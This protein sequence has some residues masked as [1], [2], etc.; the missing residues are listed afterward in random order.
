MMMLKRWLPPQEDFFQCFQTAVRHLVSAATCFE[1]LLSD[2]SRADD[3][4]QQIAQFE[5]Q[6][7]AVA[8]STYTLLYHTFI[9]PFDRH[10]IHHFI[11]HLD[12]VIDAIH[13]T[14]QR[15]WIYQMR[16]VPP[17]LK[18]GGVLIRQLSVH[19]ESAVNSMSDLKHKEKIIQ[20][21]KQ[22]NGVA[23]Q[24]ESIL[25][26]GI[27]EL[28]EQ[29]QDLKRLLKIKEIY[30]DMKIIVDAAQDLSHLIKGIVVE[31]A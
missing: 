19:M 10:D 29:E 12:D 25:L 18:Y 23:S 8:S 31:Y 9:T 26:T 28:F 21:C 14:A 6:A 15:I 7:D 27:A 13:R 16:T 1:Q 11:G 24:Y 3:L 17:G 5:N 20:T 22:I 4:V 2:L 30:E